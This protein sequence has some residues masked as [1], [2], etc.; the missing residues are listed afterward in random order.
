MGNGVSGALLLL[1]IGRGGGKG[2]AQHVLPP[3]G[4]EGEGTK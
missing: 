4:H 3:S 2:E 1:C